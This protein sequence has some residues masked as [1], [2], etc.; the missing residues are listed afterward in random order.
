[1]T[2]VRDKS[3][4]FKEPPE[5]KR[6]RSHKIIA[7]LKRHYPEVKV[8][9]R[10]SDPLQ[11]LVATILSA[12]CTDQRVNMVTPALFAK[13][14]SAKDFARANQKELEQEIRST[15]FYRS[16]AKSITNCCKALVERFDGEVPDRME[17]LIG[18]AGVGRKTANVVLGNAFGK[19]EGV[20]VDTHVKRLS[21]R[22]KFSLH[23]EPE[24]IE[25]DLM[26]LIPR[27]DWIATGDLLITHGRKTCGARKPKCL[28]CPVMNLC[29]SADEF[30]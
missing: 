6:K 12:Q 7:E 23:S 13:Y 2:V 9:L 27:K 1:M 22:L 29:P 19:A 5:E 11:L 15:G 20:V 18:L 8:A 30:L 25:S 10:H 16:K 28:E 26:E 24:K 21:G 4:R 14:R 3:S 17:D